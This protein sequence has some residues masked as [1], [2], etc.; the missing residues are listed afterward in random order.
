[1]KSKDIQNV[2]NIKYE[3][4]DGLTKIYHDLVGIV[5]LQTIKLWI[6]MIN[7]IGSINLSSPPGR[8]RTAR[9]KANILKVKHCLDQKKRISTRIFAAEIKI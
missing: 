3:N 5:S 8:P 7:N 6:K 1:M 2:V 9:T 4:G